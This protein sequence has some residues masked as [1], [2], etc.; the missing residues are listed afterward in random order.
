MK[1]IS[2]SSFY[3][4]KKL[5]LRNIKES[6]ED[7]TTHKDNFWGQDMNTSV[8][9]KSINSM[10]RRSY[11]FP[12]IDGIT[13]SYGGINLSL[14]EAVAIGSFG[15]ITTVK[16]FLNLKSSLNGVSNLHIPNWV[17]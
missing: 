16:C 14:K 12:P 1:R 9:P 5:R 6:V 13:N 15:D 17:K 11:Y 10:I 8:I 4:I 3:S 2:L 7:H